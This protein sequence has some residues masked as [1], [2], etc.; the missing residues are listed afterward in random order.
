[1]SNPSTLPDTRNAISSPASADGATR[2]DSPDG[3]TTDLCGQ[4]LAPVNRSASPAPSV[5]ATMSATYGLRS[6][7]SSASAA[8]QRSLASRLPELLD[9]HGSTMFALTWKTQVTPLGRRICALRASAPRTSGSGCTGWPSPNS[10]IVD[11]KPRPPITLGRKA[12]DPQIGLADVAVHLAPWPTSMAGTPAQK[13]YNAAGNTD[14]SRAVV[15]LVPWTTPTRSDHQG[16]ASPEAVKE[17][18]SRGHNLPEQAQMAGWVTPAALDYKDTGPIKDRS[19]G[20]ARLDQLPRQAF[21]TLGPT[22]NRSPAATEKPGQL[23]AAFSRWLM[24]YPQAW[25]VAAIDAWHRT[26]RRKA[27]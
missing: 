25:C 13:G 15:A 26:A 10:T 3:P 24:G 16:A 7:V 6:S 5:A 12:T 23:N 21:L 18:A 2:C 4:A 22:P 8:L 11:A 20:T 9:S 1:M 19:D 17:W 27:G 14:Y